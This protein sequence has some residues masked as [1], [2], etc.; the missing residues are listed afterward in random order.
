MIPESLKKG[1]LY[2][3]NY[4]KKTRKELTELEKKGDKI[5]KEL[6]KIID[7]AKRI[8]NKLKTTKR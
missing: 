7:Q 8:L 2:N 6:K 5:G 4:G 1:K 3:P